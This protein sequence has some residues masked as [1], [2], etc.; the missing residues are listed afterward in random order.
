MAKYIILPGPWI[1]AGANIWRPGD[2]VEVSSAAFGKFALSVRARL[3]LVVKAAPKTRSK[4]KK[5]KAA[6]P[7]P[8]HAE[9]TPADG[10]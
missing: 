9:P 2:Q 6:A 1:T 4:A 10:E 7:K 8:T 5:T 3:K